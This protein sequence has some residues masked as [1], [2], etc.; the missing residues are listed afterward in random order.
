MNSI[1]PTIDLKEGYAV[2][3]EG[4]PRLG[5]PNNGPNIE[6]DYEPYRQFTK[7]SMGLIME[8]MWALKCVNHRAQRWL[9]HEPYHG[10]KL[11]G[12]WPEKA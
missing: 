12:P 9:G 4:L 7:G 6:L 11:P 2:D 5:G 8:K 1:G 10:P 3:I